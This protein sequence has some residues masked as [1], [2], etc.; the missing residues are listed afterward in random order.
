M[1]VDFTVVLNQVHELE[2]LA[3]EKVDFLHETIRL[4]GNFM[5]NKLNHGLTKYLDLG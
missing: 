2:V 3:H 5:R 1:L 4:P